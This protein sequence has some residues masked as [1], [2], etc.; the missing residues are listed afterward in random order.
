MA[1]ACRY[2][3]PFQSSGDNV[4][5]K[6][7]KNERGRRMGEEGVGRRGLNYETME[8]RRVWIIAG[9]KHQQ[10]FQDIEKTSAPNHCIDLVTKTEA[11]PS[12]I[13][14]QVILATHPDTSSLSAV[15][16]DTFSHGLVEL[17][18]N[19]ED[20]KFELLKRHQIGFELD[21]RS[22]G[23]GRERGWRKDQE[24]QREGGVVCF[25]GVS[26]FDISGGSNLISFT[27]HS[28]VC[29]AFSS[30]EPSKL[31]LF[32]IKRAR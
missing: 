8:R 32:C 21:L 25:L 29:F 11:L 13:F 6:G 23:R 26:L 31:G 17:D 1:W 4:I 20:F 24:E 22:L 3:K 27:V 19:I 5:E 16:K 18:G 15:L 9:W 12:R 7:Q 2:F 10:S 28:Q 14:T 30:A